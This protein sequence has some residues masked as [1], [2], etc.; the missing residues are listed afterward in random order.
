M[1]IYS[2]DD[3]GEYIAPI[4]TVDVVSIREQNGKIVVAQYIRGREPE[5]GETAL[6][7]SYVYRGDKLEDIAKHVLWTRCGVA[8]EN[9]RLIMA[10]DDTARDTRGDSISFVYLETGNCP[11]NTSYES[12]M[13]RAFD[14]AD[15]C[16][17]TLGIVAKT[18]AI[19]VMKELLPSQFTLPRAHSVYK[20]LSGHDIDRRNFVRSHQNLW[21]PTGEKIKQTTGRPAELFVLK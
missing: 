14:H 7:G 21:E 11:A 10:A 13:P 6:P 18:Y 15:I 5:L 4:V 19:E 16:K 12:S 2:G 8:A 17:Q 3:R 20:L 9:L 1:K